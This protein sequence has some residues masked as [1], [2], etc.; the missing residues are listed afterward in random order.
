MSVELIDFVKYLVAE[1]LIPLKRMREFMLIQE[2]EAL[3]RSGTHR[4]KSKTV[5]SL[6]KKYHIS[7]SSIWSLLKHHSSRMY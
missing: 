5:R 6:A 2:F 3:Y 7:E 1:K 4:S